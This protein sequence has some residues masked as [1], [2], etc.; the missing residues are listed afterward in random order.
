MGDSLVDRDNDASA[1]E[2][3]L[4][5]TGMEG[6]AFSVV[7]LSGYAVST[8]AWAD[9]DFGFAFCEVDRVSLCSLSEFS[10]CLSI[11]VLHIELLSKAIGFELSPDQRLPIGFLDR[12][13]L[14]VEVFVDPSRREIQGV[15]GRDNATLFDVFDELRNALA[16]TIESGFSIRA[17][18]IH[19]EG[20][21]F[22]GAEVTIYIEPNISKSLFPYVVGVDLLQSLDN[23]SP[24]LFRLKKDV[25]LGLSEKYRRHSPTLESVAVVETFSGSRAKALSWQ[26]RESEEG[27]LSV[28]FDKDGELWVP[29]SYKPSKLLQ[30]VSES[31][32]GE[33]FP[34]IGTC[35]PSK[36]TNRTINFPLSDQRSDKFQL[37][38][39]KGFAAFSHCFVLW[40]C[41]VMCGL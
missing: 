18:C 36:I 29:G 19:P 3:V 16:V 28:S 8:F 13:H 2:E 41:D 38:K 40:A 32:L 25:I 10:F 14:R 7:I 12:F 21:N 39:V 11:E 15:V 22:R 27:K 6:D 1:L 33:G 5:A 24:S 20:E 17:N 31:V 30:V 35:Y 23:V 9:E 34:P 4:I 37:I 26:R